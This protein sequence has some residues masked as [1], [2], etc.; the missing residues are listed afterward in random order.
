MRNR[1]SVAIFLLLPSLH[2]WAQIG[3]NYNPSNPADPGSPAQ[4]YTLTLKSTPTNGGSFNTS[5]INIVGGKTYSLRA[6]PNTDF[7]FLAWILNGDTLSKTNSYTYTMP[8]HDVE[9]T[10]AFTYS[11][12][13]PSD[14]NII[15]PKHELSLSAVPADGGSFNT[16]STMVSEGEKYNLRAYP[17]TDFA[18]VAWV[19]EG[20]I[21]SKSASYDYIMPSHDIGITGVF[22][23]LPSSPSDPQEQ[24]LK[25]QLTLSATPINSGSFNISNERLAVGSTNSLHA[26]NNADFVFKHWMINDSILSS[27]ASFEYVMPSHNVKM[28][29]VFEYNPSSP[30]NPNRNHWDKE[31]GEVIV[32]DFT[33]GNLSSAISSVISGNS[34][35][36]VQTIIVAGQMNSNDF[37][38]ANTYTNCSILDFSRVTGISEVPS[39]AFDYTNLQK[40]Y[41]PASIEKIGDRAFA[42]CPNLTSVT[43]Y[44]MTPPILGKNVFQGLPDGFVVYVPAAAIA[45][46]Q[47]DNTWSKFTLLPIQEDISGNKEI[48][49]DDNLKIYPLPVREKL[50]VTAGEK[51]IKSVSL[52]SMNGTTIVTVSEPDT[53][54][55]LDVSPLA[56]GIYIINVATED[57]TF[58]RKIMKVE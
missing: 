49:L 30:E 34:S 29:G 26:Y 11:P 32:D 16:T 55:S 38:I 6:Y 57:K 28:T 53:H 7:A 42:E 17:N 4:E 54:I 14:P 39:Y 48:T 3:G 51:I 41:L 23:Y 52:I 40:V 12:S 8:Y 25:Y 44:A 18:F 35:K 15:A 5:S 47:N 10:G 36:D 37:G 1:I 33:P 22:E 46:Y 24:A 58:S 21:L 19:Y 27:N 56:L 9:I 31:K 43:I 20:E 50:N 13:S 2:S 45:L